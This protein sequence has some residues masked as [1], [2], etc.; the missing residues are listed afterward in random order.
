MADSQKLSK[1]CRKRKREILL[2]LYFLDMTETESLLLS[3]DVVNA[4]EKGPYVLTN[5]SRINGANALVQEELLA[6]VGDVLGGDYYVLP[7]STHELILIQDD[8]SISKEAM[9]QMVTEINSTQVPKKDL[10]SNKVQFYDSRQKQLRLD[11]NEV[12]KEKI[13]EQGKGMA[14]RKVRRNIKEPKKFPHKL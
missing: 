12:A 1:N 5:T 2:M 3:T 4:S 8:G 14:E 10:L 9:E 11:K 7:S 13:A 6:Q